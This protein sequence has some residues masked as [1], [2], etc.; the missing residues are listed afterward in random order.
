MYVCPEIFKGV[1]PE[2][3]RFILA[4]PKNS[5]KCISR[6][7]R[8]LAKENRDDLLRTRT[9]FG[10]GGVYETRTNRWGVHCYDVA[11]LEHFLAFWG[12]LAAILY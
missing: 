10:A 9:C 12:D 5:Y 4:E 8:T 3:R 7:Y 6:Y 2:Q 11:V 1:P